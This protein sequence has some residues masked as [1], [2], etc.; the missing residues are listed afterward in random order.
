MRVKPNTC[1]VRDDYKDIIT[2]CYGFFTSSNEDTNGFGS[3]LN[4]DKV[5]KSTASIS[6]RDYFL[7]NPS[8]DPHSLVNQTKVLNE[9]SSRCFD[10]CS[11][12]FGSQAYQFEEKCADRCS[13]SCGCIFYNGLDNNTCIQETTIPSIQYELEWK[14]A[15]ELGEIPFWGKLGWYPGSGYVSLLPINQKETREKL[16]HL[17]S[18]KFIDL[19]TRV[20]FVDFTLYNPLLDVHLVVRLSFELPAT[21]GVVPKSTF[22]VV[23]LDPYTNW[24]GKLRLVLETVLCIYVFGY[25]MK[26][27]L[28]IGKYGKYYF[29]NLWNV[30]GLLNLVIFIAVIAL[31]LYIMDR[32]EGIFGVATRISAIKPTEVPNFQKVAR[33]CMIF[34]YLFCK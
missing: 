27:I 12:Q 26:A 28:D 9:C 33:I 30:V 16:N 4:G 15:N 3:I 10:A 22:R 29:M 8:S 31:R 2:H 1:S 25:T 14:S 11:T 18:T 6:A 7:N 32:I 20:L 24:Q 21:G 17:K 5:T 19:G 23:D 13:S 34:L